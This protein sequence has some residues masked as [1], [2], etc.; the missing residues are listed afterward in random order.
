M[1]TIHSKTFTIEIPCLYDNGYGE[2]DADLIVDAK[3]NFCK[4][5]RYDT[6]KGSDVGIEP[7]EVEILSGEYFL[8]DQDGGNLAEIPYEDCAHDEEI[9]K[10]ALKQAGL[11]PW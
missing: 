8:I 10:Y 2:H 3:V 6:P 7:Y 9:K 4:A 5:I 11:N 1:K